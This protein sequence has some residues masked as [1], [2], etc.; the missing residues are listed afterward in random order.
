MEMTLLH[1]AEIEKALALVSRV[2]R[3]FEAP[4]YGPEG[5]AAF[6]ASMEDPV[7]TELL[8]WYGAWEENKLSGVLATRNAGE[9]IT[10]F[11]VDSALHGRGIGR[12]L[13]RRAALDCR[14]GRMTVHAAPS[15]AGFYEKL[16]FRA[17]DGQISENGILYVPMEMQLD[18]DAVSLA[19]GYCGM[20]CAL[21]SRYRTEGKSRCPGCSHDGYYTDA[22]KAHACCGAKTRVHCGLCADY[23]CRRLGGMGD[24][25]D[26]NTHSA[27][28]R[29]AAGIL[30]RGFLP[31]YRDYAERAALLTEALENYHDGRMKRY[32]CELFLW[33]DS[34]ALR[35]LM[36]A[37]RAIEGTPK[38]KGKAFKALAGTFFEPPA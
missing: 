16:G 31:W 22:C 24:F 32:L 14:M 25:S 33:R 36:R 8:T 1:R 21:C 37:A 19:Y 27:K 3:E 11:F 10:L 4:A 9:H 7:F 26:L 5:T 2:F 23:P 18:S 38:E 34:D 15:A 28:K 29:A 20:P 17:T 13:F 30:E 12:A 35:A 6:E